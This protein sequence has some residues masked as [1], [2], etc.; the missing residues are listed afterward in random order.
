MLPRR[1]AFTLVELLVVIA[2]IGV[3]VA[4][5][6]PAVQAA[7]EAA[8]RVHCQNNL[9]QLGVALHNYY[10]ARKEF[11]PAG[12]NYGWCFGAN[13]RIKP[14]EFVLNHHG[15]LLMLPYLEGNTLYE[16][17]DFSQATSNFL[18]Y[19]AVPLPDVSAVASGNAEVVSQQLSVFTC[20]S[21]IGDPLLPAAGS[22]GIGSG[23]SQGV[24][25]NYDFSVLQ[26]ASHQCD[27]WRH[28]FQTERMIPDDITGIPPRTPIRR[29][30]GENSDTTIAMVEDGTSHTVAMMETL[31]DVAN[32]PAL[33]WGYRGLYM[34]GIDLPTNGINRWNDPDTEDPRPSQ[35]ASWGFPGSLHPGGLN[36][37]MADSSVHFVSED[38]DRI[39]QS[40]LS[41]MADG[42]VVELP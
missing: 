10:S 7:R 30:F 18:L 38:M 6:L 31:F 3:L 36:V 4:L 15:L 16:K 21:D 19:N 28:Q 35:L 24:K 11:P 13:S 33:A 23:S 5:L 20:P 8:R 9:K 12:A 40:L 34:Y 27:A 32:G 37:L 22:Y 41:R 39:T 14:I 42:Q 17:V 1:H 2:I 26:P 29:M 25:T